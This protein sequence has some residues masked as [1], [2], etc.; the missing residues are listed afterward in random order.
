MERSIARSVPPLTAIEYND[1]RVSFPSR[2]LHMYDRSH[3]LPG[4]NPDNKEILKGNGGVRTSGLTHPEDESTL[5]SAWAIKSRD[6]TIPAF[7]DSRSDDRH[8]TNVIASGWRYKRSYSNRLSEEPGFGFTLHKTHA[9]RLDLH[10][11]RAGEPTAS[12]RRG[13]GKRSKNLMLVMRDGR[14]TRSL[15]PANRNPFVFLRSNLSTYTKG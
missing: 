8:E 9:H 1:G 12:H 5:G 15:V 7:F 6:P 14:G 10:I 13:R 11:D 3:I 4:S 2:F